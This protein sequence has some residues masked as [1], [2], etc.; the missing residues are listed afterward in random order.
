MS[1]IIRQ[2][3]KNM[4]INLLVTLILSATLVACGG[5][6]SKSSSN[7]SSSVTS[8]SSS[9]SIAS[10]IP[11]ISSSSSESSVA[12]LSSS[13]ASSNGSNN[14]SVSAPDLANV[15][16]LSRSVLDGV[17][18]EPETPVGEIPAYVCASGLYF[19]DDFSAGLDQRSEE[20][21]VGKVR[22]ARRWECA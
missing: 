20:R 5:S 2:R 13:S 12:S 1:S 19:C 10:S 15:R 7:P 4:R 18:T 17:P 9:T 14:C 11:S 16:P 8:S 22:G 3:E 21:R 6:N